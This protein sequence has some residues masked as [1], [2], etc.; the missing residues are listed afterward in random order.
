MLEKRFTAVASQ[1]FIADGGAN[2]SVTIPD[3][4]LFKVRQKVTLTGTALDNLELEVKRVE[5]STV[6]RVG[7]VNGAIN[8]YTDISAYTTAASAALFANEQNR[9]SIPSEEIVRATYE[10]EPV[11]AQRSVAVDSMGRASPA[12]PAWDEA[13]LTRDGDGDITQVQYSRAGAVVE[14]IDLEYNGDKSVIRVV[15]S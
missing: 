4:S 1:T 12:S 9:P 2:G 6:M 14:T 15:K 10:E 13:N 3:T 8:A 7:P 5:S 11:V